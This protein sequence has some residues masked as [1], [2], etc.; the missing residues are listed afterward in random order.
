MATSAQGPMPVQ[1]KKTSP[2]I[3]IIVG[4]LGLFMIAGLVVI[5]GGLFVAKKVHDAA[6]NPALATAK[7]M[8]AANPDVE[9]LS[10][11]DRNGTVT[12]KD[13]K[14]GK[15]M[16][17]NFDQIKQGKLTFEEDGKKVTVGSTASGIDVTSSDGSTVQIGANASSKLPDWLP[18]YPG[19][20]A[21]GTFAMQGG[22]ESGAAVSF[23]TKD[24]VSK[25]SKFYED[26]LKS[27]G[28]TTNVNL[29]SQ[30]GKASGGMIAAES[31]D[32]K[33]SAV[34]NIAA[35]DDAVTVG[36]TYSDK[37]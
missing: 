17:L 1:P 9:I 7:I 8:A 18:V 30:D 23:T 34:V 14:S 33:K 16:T 2:V 31:A 19:S 11:D 10:N 4:I 13:R 20:T 28:L 6:S 35:G 26:A 37:K 32:K 3:W 5:A 29:M 36:I 15:V 12:F 22:G 27:A 24:P 25:V 21:Q